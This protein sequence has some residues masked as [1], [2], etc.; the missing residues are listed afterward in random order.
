MTSSLSRFADN[1]GV[2]LHYLDSGGD[3]SRPP[4]VFVPGMSDVA[5]D[6]LEVLPTLGRR[7]LVVDL[8]GHGRSD[9]PE[10]GYALTDHAGDIAAVVAAAGV[11]AVHLMTFSRGTCYG[12]TW[13]AGARAQVRSVAIGDYPARE[14]ALPAE[15]RDTFLAGRWR[16]TP[17]ADRVAPHAAAATFAQAV[18]RPLWDELVQLRVPVLVARGQARVP[19]T[20]DDWDRYR[21]EVPGCRLVEFEDSPHDIFRPDRHRFPALVAEHADAAD[22]AFSDGS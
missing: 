20:A 15:T 10:T 4:I 1:G 22:T 11:A 19:L 3:D 7:C 8:R 5:H 21:T 17:V 12:L 18:D 16:G 13:A 14:I 2:R 6:Y 9:A